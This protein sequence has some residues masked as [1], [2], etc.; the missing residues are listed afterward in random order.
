VQPP[1]T[2]VSKVLRREALPLF[3]RTITFVLKLDLYNKFR[4]P[5]TAQEL[6][7]I[8]RDPEFQ[9]LALERLPKA[10][11]TGLPDEHLSHICRL[12]LENTEF[13]AAKYL[14]DLG[15]DDADP[16]IE[17]LEE[18]CEGPYSVQ[19]LKE[20]EQVLRK[21]TDQMTMR[22]EA[23]KLRRG[24]IKAFIST[25]SPDMNEQ[26]DEDF[27]EQGSKDGIVMRMVTISWRR[28]KVRRVSWGRMER[29]VE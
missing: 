3:Y 12:E 25:F 28:M 8:I 11:W 19:S 29:R 13:F 20:H 18:D 5:R 24:D 7:A 26:D 23:K 14:I 4:E 15:A 22:A 10:F 27:R 2:K 1:V 17:F 16:H 9:R 6:V 21:V